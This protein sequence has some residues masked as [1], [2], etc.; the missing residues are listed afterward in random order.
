[1][2]W[3]WLS[4]PWSAWRSALLIVQPATVVQW[5]R[6]GFKLHWRWKSRKKP[7]GPPADREI[8]DLIRRMSHENPT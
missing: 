4:H 6:R 3:A 1:M 2:F 5:H 8:R 7:G